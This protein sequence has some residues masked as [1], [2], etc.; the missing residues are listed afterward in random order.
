[1]L[2]LI[3]IHCHESSGSPLKWLI[4][5]TEHKNINIE[6]STI[7]IMYNMLINIMYY[8]LKDTFVCGY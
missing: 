2:V 4:S 6:I 7:I 5:L 8:Y 1:M 3:I